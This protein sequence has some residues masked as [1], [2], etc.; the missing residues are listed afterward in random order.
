MLISECSVVSVTL[1]SR[2]QLLTSLP[3]AL[4]LAFFSATLLTPRAIAVLTRSLDEFSRP[5]MFLSMSMSFPT[6]LC[7]A[8]SLRPLLLPPYRTCQTF[9]PFLSAWLHHRLHCL[10]PLCRPPPFINRRL[11]HCLLPH[12]LPL[13]LKP[14][15]RRRA[16]CACWTP[17]QS[18]SRRHPS[19]QLQPPHQ[20]GTR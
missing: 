15:S 5:V 7:R 8:R 20:S 3:H 1:T 14:L 2:L 10:L 13:L 18:L 17:H 12:F 9:F 16:P 4:Y 19:L 6:G 11:R